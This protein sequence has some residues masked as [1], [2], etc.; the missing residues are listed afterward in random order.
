MP[1][2]DEPKKTVG[3]AAKTSKPGKGVKTKATQ[4]K[5]P[6]KKQKKKPAQNQAK[7]TKT[8]F[9]PEAAQAE[10]VSITGSFNEWDPEANVMERKT[11]GAWQC[12]LVIDP[13]EYE[14]RFFVDGA[15]CDDPANMLKRPNEFGTQNCVLIVQD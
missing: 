10:Q 7:K 3:N 8:T 5:V 2:K 1:N 4:A 9:K 14:Y 12:T 11:D 13:G 6:V 15:W